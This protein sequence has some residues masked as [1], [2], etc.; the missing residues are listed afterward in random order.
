MYKNVKLFKVSDI[1][2]CENLNHFYSL[3][4]YSCHNQ[5]VWKD[6]ANVL[7]KFLKFITTASL[8]FTV[9]NFY[10]FLFPILQQ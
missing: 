8:S 7:I 2:S 5:S 1:C 10:E 6:A 3:A 9:N 4:V